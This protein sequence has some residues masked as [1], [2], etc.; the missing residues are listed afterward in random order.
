MFNRKRAPAPRDP[1]LQQIDDWH[2]WLLSAHTVRLAELNLPPE[3]HDR[4]LA[5][6][7]RLAMAVADRMR[8]D[9]LARYHP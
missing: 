3:Q 4:E 6:V 7:T 9:Y 8:S 2:Q 5:D 1:G